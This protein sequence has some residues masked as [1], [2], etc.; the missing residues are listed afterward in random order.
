MAL[1]VSIEITILKDFFFTQYF[2]QKFSQKTSALYLAY[3]GGVRGILE[4]FIP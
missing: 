1:I 2:P 4:K 3:E